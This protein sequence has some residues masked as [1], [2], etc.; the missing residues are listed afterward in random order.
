[1]ILCHSTSSKHA[2]DYFQ[3]ENIMNDGTKNI[4]IHIRVDSF[5][6]LYFSNLKLFKE[7]A[8]WEKKKKRNCQMVFQNGCIVFHPRQHHVNVPLTPY[9]RQRWEVTV[10]CRRELQ[11]HVGD[12]CG[13]LLPHRR[14]AGSSGPHSAR[15]SGQD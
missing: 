7:I 10:A 2:Q 5:I 1:M 12:H 9:P 15:P 3:F 4:G 13:K 11:G 8:E 14:E 6:A